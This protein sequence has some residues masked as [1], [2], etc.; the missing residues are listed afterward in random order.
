MK[1]KDKNN[2]IENTFNQFDDDLWIELILKS[3]HSVKMICMILSLDL[4]IEKEWE[5]KH[6]EN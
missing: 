5:K 1:H 3:P 4:Q 6:G 2:A